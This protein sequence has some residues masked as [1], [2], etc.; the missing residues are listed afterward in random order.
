MNVYELYFAHCVWYFAHCVKAVTGVRIMCAS[1]CPRARVCGNCIDWVMLKNQRR[2]NRFLDVSQT[3]SSLLFTC[4]RPGLSF[5]WK[6]GTLLCLKPGNL[7]LNG[8]IKKCWTIQRKCNVG[9]GSSGNRQTG[10]QMSDQVTWSR[11]HVC[12]V[13]DELQAAR[14]GDWP[15]KKMLKFWIFKNINILFSLSRIWLVG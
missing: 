1:A 6:P 14:L 15:V 7:Y 2:N 10:G 4:R 8:E 13:S 3:G 12:L 9:R 11:A 5:Q